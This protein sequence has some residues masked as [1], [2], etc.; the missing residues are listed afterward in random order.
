MP[1][2]WM[3]NNKFIKTMSVAV[4]SLCYIPLLNSIGNLLV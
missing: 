3:G 1:Y 4:L 2:K